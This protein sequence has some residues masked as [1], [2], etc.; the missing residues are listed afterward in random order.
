M[1][2]HKNYN[3]YTYLYTRPTVPLTFL[4]ILFTKSNSRKIYV[5]GS[6][7]FVNARSIILVSVLP[8]LTC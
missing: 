4:A 1:G 5:I 6:P 7:Y 8:N 2:G 3:T